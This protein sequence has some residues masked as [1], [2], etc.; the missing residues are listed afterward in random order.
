VK[1]GKAPGW[2]P[3]LEELAVDHRIAP[4]AA[5]ARDIKAWQVH[6]PAA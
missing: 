5:I 1:R 6:H 2:G 3:G 4:A